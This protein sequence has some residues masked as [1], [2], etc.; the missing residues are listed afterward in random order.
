VPV[1]AEVFVEMEAVIQC[2]DCNHRF[3]NPS[4]GKGESL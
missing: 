3:E 2:P 1:P 4:L